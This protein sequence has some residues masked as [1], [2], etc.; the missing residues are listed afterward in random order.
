MTFVLPELPYHKGDFGDKVI[1][2]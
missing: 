1:S 2:A